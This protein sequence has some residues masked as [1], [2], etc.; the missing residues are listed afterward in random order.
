MVGSQDLEAQKGIVLVV[1]FKDE[2]AF[3]Q[4][5]A[6][7]AAGYIVVVRRSIE[8]AFL[9]LTENID[10]VTAIVLDAILPQNDKDGDEAIRLRQERI[11]VFSSHLNAE[12]HG[13]QELASSFKQDARNLDS[14]IFEL[15]LLEGGCELVERCLLSQ[16][17][18]NYIVDHKL[19][20]SIVYFSDRNDPVMV[21]RAYRLSA[22]GKV[23]WVRIDRLGM[24]L[25]YM[26]HD[27][28]ARMQ[29]LQ[30]RQI[31]IMLEALERVKN[32]QGLSYW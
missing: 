8:N 9:W 21:D 10:Q 25:I 26:I 14:Q 29:T 4:K 15:I 16:A 1:Q 32:G 17:M 31:S 18:K 24:R 27:E 2:L 5:E 28:G 22:Q 12:E 3:V 19:N 23:E 11:A 7:E 13:E 6:L 20:L 30:N